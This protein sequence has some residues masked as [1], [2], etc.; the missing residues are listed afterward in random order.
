M[1]T[2][3]GHALQIFRTGVL[4]HAVSQIVD[5]ALRWG[6]VTGTRQREDNHHHAGPLD[7]VTMRDIGVCR[8]YQDYSSRA[9]VPVPAAQ[10]LLRIAD[11]ARWG[12][13]R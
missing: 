11:A 12:L 1:E 10:R 7:A 9:D 8:E 2:V 5:A 13:Q 6:L 4:P 3:M